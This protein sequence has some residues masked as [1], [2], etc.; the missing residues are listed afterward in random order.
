MRKYLALAA[1]GTATLLSGCGST[2]L[3]NRDR[4][5]EFA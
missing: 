4:P 5:D 1:I 2:G 3:F